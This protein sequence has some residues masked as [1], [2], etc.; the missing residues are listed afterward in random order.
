MS[1][2]PTLVLVLAA[3]GFAAC[4]PLPVDPSISAQ[5]QYRLERANQVAMPGTLSF[6]DGVAFTYHDGTHLTLQNGHYEMI[7]D[8]TARDRNGE[9]PWVWKMEG[10]YALRGD[11][12]VLDPAGGQWNGQRVPLKGGTLTLTFPGDERVSQMVFSR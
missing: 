1:K 4:G 5:G 2:A 9:Y 8:Y 10:D 12:V 7:L 3:A 11:T 6:A